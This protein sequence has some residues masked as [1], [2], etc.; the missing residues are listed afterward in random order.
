M[1]GRTYQSRI[2]PTGMPGGPRWNRVGSQMR[3]EPPPG[4]RLAP[5]LP[6]TCWLGRALSIPSPFVE[7]EELLSEW[8]VT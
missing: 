3:I 1:H 8:P 5:Y 2:L 4:P 6:P 7:T